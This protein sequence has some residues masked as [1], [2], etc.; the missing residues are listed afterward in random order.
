VARKSLARDGLLVCATAAV[1]TA[2]LV[3]L[4]AASQ[5]RSQVQFTVWPG[6]SARFANMDWN[7]DYLAG[8]AG[9][10]RQVACARESTPNGVRT[11]VDGDEVSLHRCGGANAAGRLKWCNT[12][13]RAKRIP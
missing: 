7:C 2:I 1:T 4:S 9:S 13:R 11:F 5:E 3:P 10:L 8:S 12:L 6:S